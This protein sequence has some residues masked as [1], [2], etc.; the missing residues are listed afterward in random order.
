VHRKGVKFGPD[1]T[2]LDD[3]PSVEAGELV[4][5]NDIRES[6]DENFMSFPGTWEVDARLCLESIAPRPATV[7]ALV[8]SVDF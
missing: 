8:C 3:L 2:N 7:L 4:G 6:L 5:D 1:F